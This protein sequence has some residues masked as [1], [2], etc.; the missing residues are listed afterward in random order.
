MKRDDGFSMP[1]LVIAMAIMAVVTASVFGIM[2]P[3]EGTF[4]AQPEAAD[5]QQ[6]LRV[7]ADTLTKDLMM[8]GAGSYAGPTA[9]V[10]NYYFA[11]ILPYGAGV[12]AS[13]N[14]NSIATFRTDTIT[15]FYVRS[16]DA[17]MIGRTYYLKADAANNL[18]QLVSSD[19]GSNADIPVVDHVV[20]LAFDYYGD[21]QPPALNTPTCHANA[22]VPC[23]SYGPPPPARGVQTTAYPA[24]ENCV[25]AVDP[26]S[27]LQVPRLPVLGADPNRTAPLLLTSSE[28]T[29]GPWCPDAVNANRYD[30]DLLRI[31]TVAVILRVE[32][33]ADGMRGPAGTLFT[34][35]G[36]AKN[37]TKFLP[38][39]EI[40]FQVS[41]RNLN[42]GR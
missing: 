12:L 21:P 38:D 28:L 19:G 20:G 7:A 24:G 27:G 29:D 30:A 10:L 17:Q 35:A 36:T 34:R 41:P 39:Q 11:P 26:T 2:N 18:Y 4:A 6:R 23:T 33:A 42:L 16:A 5:M 13:P 32:A 25:F 31:R 22:T 9:G 40:R 14:P 37:I 1:E 3:A 15:I 8:A